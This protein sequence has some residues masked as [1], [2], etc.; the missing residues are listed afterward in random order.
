MLDCMLTYLICW[1]QKTNI[2]RDFLEDIEEEPAPRSD[3]LFAGLHTC[4]AEGYAK[5]VYIRVVVNA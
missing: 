1:L 5:D 2:I 4:I 3:S